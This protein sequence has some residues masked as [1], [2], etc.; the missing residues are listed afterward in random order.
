MNPITFVTSFSVPGYHLYGQRFIDSFVEHCA[1]HKLVI[2][3]ESQDNVD[4]HDRLTWKNLDHIE[5][6]KKFIE[7]WGN[8]PDK[9]GSASHPN[10]QAIRFCHKVFAITDAIRRSDTKWVIWVDGDV[11]WTAKPEHHVLQSMLDNRDLAFLGRT[12][13]PYTECGFV[14]YRAHSSRVIAMAHDMLNYY[15]SGEI[16]T[17]PKWDWHDSRCF[18]ICRERSGIPPQRQNNLSEGIAGWHPWPKTVLA[19][20]CRHNKGPG[21]KS[22]AYG[23]VCK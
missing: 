20:F 19:Q 12:D 15:T 5:D 9:V 14:A 2:Y 23:G 11:E 1:P 17:R 7:D 8:D 16:F 6:R 3:H 21:R 4:F 10:S 22:Q 18:D 13:A